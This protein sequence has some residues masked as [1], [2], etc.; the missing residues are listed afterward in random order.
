VDA[1]R[2]TQVKIAIASG[3]GGTGKTLV[4]TNLALVSPVATC[5][6]DCDV[7]EPNG[8]LFLH[9]R[10][11]RSVQVSRPI[12]TV[13]QGICDLCGA[14][15]EACRFNAIA[16]HPRG[17]VVFDDLC[18]G[19]G[20]CSL[21]C[22][23]DAI[24]EESREIGVVEKGKAGEIDFIGGR[25]KIGEPII[26]P[27]IRAVKRIIPDN[28]LVLID[29]APGTSCPVIAA[30]RDVDYCLLVT[31]PTPFGLNDLAL[32]VEMIRKLDLP[33]GVLINRDGTGY[34]DTERYCS[35]EGLPVLAR[36][37]EDR[38]IAEVYSR[39]GMIVEE[40]PEMRKSFLRLLGEIVSEA[41]E[42]MQRR[43]RAGG[44]AAEV[45]EGRH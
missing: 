23:V 17:V 42:S 36:I 21:A 45:T 20:G 33:V 12:P 26:P 31:E 40:M 19:C 4:A 8:H 41:K 14:C 11:Y 43:T 7:E 44:Q 9:P 5:Y 25:L 34:G 16:V 29:V 13:D 2:S 28:E 32:A 1:T 38:S 35:E 39:G 18:H 24:R 22:P 6:V 30:I 37:P 15:A 27:V 3:K 10:I